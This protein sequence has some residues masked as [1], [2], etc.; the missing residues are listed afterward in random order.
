MWALRSV[1]A[2]YLLSGLWCALNPQ[3]T[4]DFLGYT[5]T[6]VGLSEF[7]AVYGGLQV[8]LGVAMLIASVKSNYIE[9]SLMFALMTSLGLLVFRLV[10][11]ARFDAS[12]GIIAMAILEAIIAIVLGLQYKKS[13][14]SSS[15]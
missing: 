5:V 12:E 14:V 9:A 6:N 3:V 13:M 11:L 2:L 8:G 7:F 1:G 4:S 10:A 15:L